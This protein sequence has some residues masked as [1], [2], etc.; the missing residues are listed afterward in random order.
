MNL[1]VIETSGQPCGAA[2]MA[3]GQVVAERL[4]ADPMQLLRNL[5]AE[6][7]EM[8]AQRSLS[9]RD[10]DVF[11]VDQGPGT[12]TGLRIGVMTAKTWAHTLQKP[13]VGVCSLDALAHAHGRG[14]EPVLTVVR[15]R[16]G[17]AYAR[18][19]AGSEI[20][21]PADGGIACGDMAGI[22]RLTAA[23]GISAV[24]VV[25]DALSRHAVELATELASA[26][27]AATMGPGAAPSPAQLA[28]LAA[29]RA[30]RGEFTDAMAAV[31]TYVAPPP[32][33]PNLRTGSF[34][35]GTGG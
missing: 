17:T 34:A 32:A 3:D 15:S 12:F 1:L 23:A 25:G 7:V 14:G 2:L 33:K 8:L 30:D 16:F 9:L 6:V 29:A 24:R 31:P 22:A 21:A 26:G 28:T 5:T 10:I 20:V 27:V 18:V 4:V 35:A 13:L 11:G 19:Y